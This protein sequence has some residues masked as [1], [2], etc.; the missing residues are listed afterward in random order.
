MDILT[1]DYIKGV[2][3][4]VDTLLKGRYLTEAYY[5]VEMLNKQIFDGSKFKIIN[6]PEDGYF[7]KHWPNEF[8]A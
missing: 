8:K 1:N 7:C 4:S 6:T 2:I 5:L 3:I